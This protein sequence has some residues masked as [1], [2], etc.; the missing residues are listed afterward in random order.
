[1]RKTL[2]EQKIEIDTKTQRLDYLELEY[3]STTNKL[4]EYEELYG[5]LKRDHELAVQRLTE[6][7]KEK[8]KFE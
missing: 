8:T 4:K 5:G 3:Y 1:M 7:Q 6:T 2:D